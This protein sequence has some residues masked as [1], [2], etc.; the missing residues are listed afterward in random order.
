M[1]ELAPTPTRVDL[2]LQYLQ[3]W[4]TPF[5]E[6]D[7]KT[8]ENTPF[9]SGRTSAIQNRSLGVRKVGRFRQTHWTSPPHIATLTAASFKTVSIVK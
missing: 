8:T 1:Q 3:E 6:N 7:L 4:P 9:T 2:V 5:G